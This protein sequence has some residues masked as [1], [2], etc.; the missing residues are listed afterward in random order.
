[1]GSVLLDVSMSLDGFITG[2][3]PGVDLPLGER[4][5]DWMISPG[6]S[7]ETDW[8][9]SAATGAEAPAVHRG[10]LAALVRLA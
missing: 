5:H 4:L 7:Q 10:S 3:N 8:H 1:V 9:Q 2:P 6:R